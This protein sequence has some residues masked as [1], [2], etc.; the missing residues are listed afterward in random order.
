MTLFLL[1]LALFFIP[2]LFSAFR[3]REPGKDLRKNLGETKYMGLYSLVTLAGFVL[4]VMGVSVKIWALGHLLSNGELNAVILFGLFLAYAVIDRI[5]VKRRPVVEGPA[6]V[7][8]WDV[9]A[10]FAGLAI[11]ILLFIGGHQL[12][13]GVPIA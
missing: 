11:Y 2:H 5:A 8:K 12:L 1:G 6:P 10:I 4:L 7:A 9:I 3:S 13:F